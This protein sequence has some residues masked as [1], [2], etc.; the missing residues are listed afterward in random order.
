MRAASTKAAV[1]SARAAARLTRAACGL[2]GIAIASTRPRSIPTMESWPR[3]SSLRHRNFKSASAHS[4]ARRRPQTSPLHARWAP[5]ESDRGFQAASSG[6]KLCDRQ[7]F[8]SALKVTGPEQNPFL[9]SALTWSRYLSA[10]MP[11]V[12][13]PIL[14][15]SNLPIGPLIN[16]R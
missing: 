11:A 10:R 3:N 7:N 9:V 4:A 16:V 12:V 6:F 5:L 14:A 13:L 15:S 8:A 1:R 2:T